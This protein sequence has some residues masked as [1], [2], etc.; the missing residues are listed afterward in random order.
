MNGI[1]FGAYLTALFVAL[2]ITGVVAWSWWWVLA[3]MWMV[4][5]IV[6]IVIGVVMIIFVRY[7]LVMWILPEN[8]VF[9]EKYREEHKDE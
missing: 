7:C 5:I 3:P 2:K 4:G 9:D 8:M 6:A 1:Q